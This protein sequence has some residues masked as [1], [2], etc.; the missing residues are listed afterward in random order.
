MLTASEINETMDVATS[1][2]DRCGFR[3]KK[4][5]VKDGYVLTFCGHHANE[6]IDSLV[7]AGWEL[8]D[9]VDLTI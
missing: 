7:L 4:F 2:C 3:A 8:H 5:A 9:L 1:G 6:H